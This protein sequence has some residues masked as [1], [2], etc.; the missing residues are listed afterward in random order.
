MANAPPHTPDRPRPTVGEWL[1]VPINVVFVVMGL[2]ILP[3][4]PDGAIVTIAFFGTCLVV[5]LGTVVRKLR[6][7]RFSADT[8]AVAGGVPIRPSATFMPLLGGWLAIL[9][10]VLFVFGHD[11]PIVFR[12]LAAFIAVVGVVLLGLSFTG[13]VPG[14]F[15]RFD[16]EGLTIAQRTWAARIPWDDITGVHEGEL[17][18]N[19]V[20]LVTVADP[21][22]L[23]IAPAQAHAIAMRDIGRTRG[24]MGADFMVMARHYGIDLPVLAGTI[25]RYVE[26]AAARAELIPRLT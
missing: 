12:A 7:R 25:A 14:G 18:S 15:L 17:S 20:L 19:A 26:D 13:R 21:T 8:I 5:S 23:E 3:H 24:L 4:E 2:I 6:D 22:R 9:G 11:Y 16:P 10:V 1:L